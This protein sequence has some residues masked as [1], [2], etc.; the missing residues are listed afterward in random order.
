MMNTWAIIGLGFISP[1]HKKGIEST[2]GTLITT[3]DID[4]AKGADF[5]SFDALRSSNMWKRVS[6]VAVCTPNDTHS[7]I[8]RA[9]L[10]D[11][12]RVLCEKP[13]TLFDDFSGLDGVNVVLQLRYNPAVI[14]LKE[15]GVQDIDIKV[16]TYRE[17]KYWDSWKGQPERSGG[18]LLNMGVHYI[19]LLIHLL[20]DPIEILESTFDIKYKATGSVRFQRGIGRYHIELSKEPCET[21]RDIRVNGKREDI[22]G[23]TIPLSDSTNMQ[24]KDLHSEVYR[25]FVDGRGIPLEE[26]RRALDLIS[27]LHA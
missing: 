1:R 17:Q 12:K 14:A 24:Y 16:V 25:N 11:G 18:V 15:A 20:G 6:H 3:C 2:G 26:A 7:D 19:D 5:L 10:D 8:V 9:C 4:P 22:E 21:I 13:L 27:D 23:A